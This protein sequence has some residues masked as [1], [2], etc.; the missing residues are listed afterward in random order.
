[1][2]QY[3]IDDYGVIEDKKYLKTNDDI[4][5]YFKDVGRDYF[6]CGQGYYQD[7]AEV[8]VKIG[9]EFIKVT[10]I[11]E[12]ESAKQDR[13]ARLYWVESIKDVILEDMDKPE[14]L[15]RKS[16]KITLDNLTLN[17]INFIEH[18]LKE[19]NFKYKIE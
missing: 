19:N 11:A 3:L 9:D 10:I 12:I 15:D 7:S 8:I 16:Y 17:D 18:L 5:P 1:M 6:D 14:P 13:G 2:E 4:L